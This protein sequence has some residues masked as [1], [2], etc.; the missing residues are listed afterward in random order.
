MRDHRVTRRSARW[1]R[2]LTSADQG[3][4]IDQA[5]ACHQLSLNISVALDA[6]IKKIEIYVRLSLFCVESR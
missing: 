6:I 2:A 3:K 1:T 5:S 4:S